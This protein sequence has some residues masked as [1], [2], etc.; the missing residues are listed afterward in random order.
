ME[1]VSC[2]L[3]GC[4]MYFY[5]TMLTYLYLCFRFVVIIQFVFLVT[6]QQE[7]H[8]CLC[9]QAITSFRLK[10]QDQIAIINAGIPRTSGITLVPTISALDWD[11]E[12]LEAPVCSCQ[13]GTTQSCSFPFCNYASLTQTRR[14]SSSSAIRLK[15][16][17]CFLEEWLV[18]ITSCVYTTSEIYEEG[19]VNTETRIPGCA[20]VGTVRGVGFVCKTIFGTG[21]VVV[22]IGC[23][24]LTEDERL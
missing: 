24:D 6:F 18:F 14:R 5:F 17:N 7:Q 22:C 19:V 9:I 8:V 13:R 4:K 1:V 15:R 12:E 23:Y 21:R 2:D 16:F 11:T 20:I 10:H 3:G